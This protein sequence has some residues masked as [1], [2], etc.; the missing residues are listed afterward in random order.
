MN[1]I[2][3]KIE[4][5]VTSGS[6]SVVTLLINGT[7]R[8]K[9]IIIETP[10]TAQYLKTG[11]RMKALFK[12]TEVILG[13]DMEPALGIENK[14]PGRITEIEQ[15]ILLSRVTLKTD[16]GNLMAL[17]GTPFIDGMGLKENSEVL[18]MIGMNAIM[19]SE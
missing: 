12:E 15:G 2:E 3:G 13:T 5:V 1:R 16:I 19:L 7:M 8:L 14:I 6:L 17:I 18:A 4:K 11:N 10:E 9:T